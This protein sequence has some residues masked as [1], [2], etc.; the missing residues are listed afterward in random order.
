MRQYNHFTV[1]TLEKQ[2]RKKQSRAGRSPKGDTAKK[3]VSLTIDPALISQVDGFAAIKGIS[4]SAALEKIIT[5]WLRVPSDNPVASTAS[6]IDNSLVQSDCL[7]A[8]PS[9]G[10]AIMY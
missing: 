10:A 1:S 9:L 3:I 4:R 8:S 2:P 7:F 5:D 6:A